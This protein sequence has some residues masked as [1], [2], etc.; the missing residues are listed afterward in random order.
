MEKTHNLRIEISSM[1]QESFMFFNEQMSWGFGSLENELCKVQCLNRIQP[2][3]INLFLLEDKDC[4]L[5]L[6]IA[7]Q[8]SGVL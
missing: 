7:H 1:L 8:V 6:W 4:L 5:C 3:Y 2:G